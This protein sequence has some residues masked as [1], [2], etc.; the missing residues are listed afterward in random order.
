MILVRYI[1]FLKRIFLIMVSVILTVYVCVVRLSDVPDSGSFLIFSAKG[2]SK[3]Q[4]DRFRC[5]IALRL[6]KV[7]YK[8]KT[9]SDKVVRHSL[10]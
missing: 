6:K 7:C 1:F 10:A 5:K 3:T 2:C 9:V 8:V 4:N